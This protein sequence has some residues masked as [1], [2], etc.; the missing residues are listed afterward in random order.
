MTTETLT[1]ADFLLARIAHRERQILD[2]WDSDAESRVATMWT[3][4]EPGYTTVAADQGDGVWI[5]D[6]REVEDARH[7]CILFDPREVLAECEAKRRIVEHFTKHRNWQE[8]YGAIAMVPLKALASVYAD[9]PD[10]REEW[11]P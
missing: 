3:G 4:G 8:F 1:L 10:Y 6:G 7:V 9:H 11:R 2:G 5:A